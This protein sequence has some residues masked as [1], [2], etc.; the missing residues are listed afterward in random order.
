MPSIPSQLALDLPW[1]SAD[2]AED[3]LVAPSNQHAVDWIDRWPDWPA[4]ALVLSGPSA[5]GKSHLA[6]LWARR[7]DAVMA[8]PEG[9]EALAA[10]ALAS[11]A[12]AVLLD[13][14]RLPFDRSAEKPLLHALNAVRE[15]GGSLLMVAE[16][17]QARWGVVLP[18]LAS[19]LLSLP[20]A[21]IGAP[22]DSLLAA[23]LVKLFRDRGLNPAAELIPYLLRRV[24]RSGAAV[25]DVVAALDSAALAAGKPVTIAFARSVLAGR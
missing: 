17:P 7:A 25:R 19:R 9:L 18:D 13:P 15:A 6:S 4:Q 21:E 12:P 22:D 3:F 10:M 1:R 24:E 11:Q 5:S 8:T 23:L 14:V 2:G 16:V 20:H